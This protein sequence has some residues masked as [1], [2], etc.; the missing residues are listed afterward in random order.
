MD[1]TGTVNR[2][3]L[4]GSASLAAI[5][6][7]LPAVDADRA[8]LVTLATGLIEGNRGFAYTLGDVLY[9]G[10]VFDYGRYYGLAAVLPGKGENT[11][12][13][14]IS[15]QHIQELGAPAAA[16]EAIDALRLWVAENV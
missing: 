16:G 12:A 1:G 11:H 10:K 6:A 5:A 4:I 13:V 8:I 14:A 2:S 15:R 3:G 7:T 9:A